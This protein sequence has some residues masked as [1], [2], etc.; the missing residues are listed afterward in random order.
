MRPTG[1]ATD[2]V[3]TSASTSLPGPGD[4]SAE[5][6][7]LARSLDHAQYVV[8]GR[9]RET[10]KDVDGEAENPSGS[11]TERLVSSSFFSSI[12][13]LSDGTAGENGQTIPRARQFRKE[14]AR[15]TESIESSFTGSCRSNDERSLRLPWLTPR[16]DSRSGSPTLETQR[17]QTR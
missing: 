6:V 11:S 17:R 2:R 13:R 10:S 12:C 4:N 14:S 15:R 5:V 1:T 16:A 7:E 8:R 9:V 3:E